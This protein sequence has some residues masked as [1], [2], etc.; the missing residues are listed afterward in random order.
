MPRLKITAIMVVTVNKKEPVYAHIQ[1]VTKVKPVSNK[2]ESDTN[3]R[4]N[5]I[6]FKPKC[7]PFT[8]NFP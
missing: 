2:M 8:Q 6:L 7:I 4:S 1:I 5:N 3:S